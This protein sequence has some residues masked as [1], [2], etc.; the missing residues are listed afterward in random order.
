MCWTDSELRMPYTTVPTTVQAEDCVC[1][2]SVSV[3][4]TGAGLTA[5]WSY[6]PMYA[7]AMAI[8]REIDV[9]ARK[10]KNS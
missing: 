8:V 10:G 5:V 7:Q 1:P 3:W 4:V 6:V 2:T 9:H